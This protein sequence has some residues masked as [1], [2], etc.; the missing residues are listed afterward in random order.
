MGSLVI[1]DVF[2][3]YYAGCRSAG[4][5]KSQAEAKPLPAMRIQKSALD[6]MWAR[7]RHRT[8]A[9]AHRKG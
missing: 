3:P 6:R 4:P 2:E 5:E 1:Q 9:E 7:K 8:D